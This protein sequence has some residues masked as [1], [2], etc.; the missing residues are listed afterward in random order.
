MPR[1]IP[2]AERILKARE[3][4]QKAREVPLSI[5][6][7][8]YDLNYIATVKGLLQDARDMVKFISYIPSSTADMKNQVKLIYQEADQAN[9]EILHS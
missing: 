8:K 7:G 3:L 4:I 2:A 9:Q 5:E 1:L 6:S